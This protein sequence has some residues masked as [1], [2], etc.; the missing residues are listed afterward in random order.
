[1]EYTYMDWETVPVPQKKPESR[2]LIFTC[3]D[4]EFV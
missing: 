2:R 1:M 3:L 4:Q